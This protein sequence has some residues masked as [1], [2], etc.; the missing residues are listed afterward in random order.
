MR[1]R[2][3]LGAA[4]D[5]CRERGLLNQATTS[6]FGVGPGEVTPSFTKR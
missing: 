1:R 2:V 4:G 5:V 6:E 3:L